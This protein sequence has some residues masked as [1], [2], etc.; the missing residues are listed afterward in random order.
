MQAIQHKSGLWQQTACC[1]WGSQ[2]QCS[3][4]WGEPLWGTRQDVMPHLG[5]AGCYGDTFQNSNWFFS[6]TI[7]GWLPSNVAWLQISSLI[8]NVCES[9]FGSPMVTNPLMPHL[10]GTPLCSFFI[11]EICSS[12]RWSCLLK[13]NTLPMEFLWTSSNH[14]MNYLYYKGIA[15]HLSRGVEAN[16]M[17][18]VHLFA[19]QFQLLFKLMD[20]EYSDTWNLY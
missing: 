1:Q 19:P 20:I 3:R 9:A 13:Y 11:S 18:M 16:L 10:A 6:Q 15:L 8:L 4:R 14:F 5:W 7:H 12:L 17:L 2:I